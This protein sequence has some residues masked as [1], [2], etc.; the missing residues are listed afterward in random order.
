MPMAVRLVVDRRGGR[1]PLVVELISRAAAAL[2]AAV[3]MPTELP[4]ATAPVPEGVRVTLL[5]PVS[6]VP[7]AKVSA[8]V[9]VMEPVLVPVPPTPTAR[10]PLAR[11]EALVVS[12]LATLPRPTWLLVRPVRAEPL[13]EGAR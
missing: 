3:P 8:P 10:V 12:T 6:P 7:A 11:L 9:P 5:F 13:P 1:K 4:S 2:G